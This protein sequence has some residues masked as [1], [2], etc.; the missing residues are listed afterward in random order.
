MSHMRVHSAV[1]FVGLPRPCSRIDIDIPFPETE[2]VEV[3]RAIFAEDAKQIVDA[4]FKALP[5]GTIDHVMILLMERKASV[6]RVAYE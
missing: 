4:L 2:S 6:F 1:G 5:G 3:S